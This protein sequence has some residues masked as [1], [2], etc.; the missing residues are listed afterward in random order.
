MLEVLNL[1]HLAESELMDLVLEGRRQLSQHTRRRYL[2]CL[3]L[4]LHCL[5]PLL[6][7][8]LLLLLLF[9]LNRGRA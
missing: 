8:L 7:L 4:L 1:E 3:L 9:F 5:L 2:R 6:R